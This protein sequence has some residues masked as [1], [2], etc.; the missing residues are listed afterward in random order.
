MENEYKYHFFVNGEY[1]GSYRDLE[2]LQEKA[3]YFARV[4][5]ENCL[6]EM[7]DGRK[8]LVFSGNLGCLK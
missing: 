2:Y 7:D 6:I 8:I 4:L 5:N 1:K 3:D